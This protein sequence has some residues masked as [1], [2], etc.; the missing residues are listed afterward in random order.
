MV[1]LVITVIVHN[2][3]K[4]RKKLHRYAQS[5]FYTHYVNHIIRNYL[6]ECK[7]GKFENINL[8][9]KKILN[10]I[11]N[12]FSMLIGKQCRCSLKVLDSNFNISTPCRD[13]I[14]ENRVHRTNSSIAHNLHNNSDFYNLWYGTGG[15]SRF[16]LQNDLKKLWK[17]HKYL[18]SSFEE[19]GCPEVKQLFGGFSVVVNWNLPYQS[20]LVFPIRYFERYQPPTSDGEIPD[21]WSFLGFLCIDCES[22]NVFDERYS[23]ELGAAFSDL[24]YAFITQAKHLKE[25]SNQGEKET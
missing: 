2:Y 14:G 7:N 10:A 13:D 24:L 22:K 8:I 12:C 11:A 15:C 21:H 9:N 17:S 20:T 23:P 1:A 16:Y 18:N 6:A 5:V 19:F 25:L 3:I 4:E